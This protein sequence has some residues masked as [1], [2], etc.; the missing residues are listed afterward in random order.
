FTNCSVTAGFAA[1]CLPTSLDVRYAEIRSYTR[2]MGAAVWVHRLAPVLVMAGLPLLG[3][4][5]W[6]AVPLGSRAW[7]WPLLAA[8]PVW[9][10]ARLSSESAR[11]R[12]RGRR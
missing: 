8:P 12:P 3:S 4:N 6:R 5:Q 11:G 9:R 7:P 10:V 2:E 1:R